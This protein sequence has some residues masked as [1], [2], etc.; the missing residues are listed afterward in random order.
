M[1]ATPPQIAR[2]LVF[3]LALA[4]VP[5][6]GQKVYIETDGSFDFTTHRR[7]QWREHPL[8]EHDPV[9]QQAYVAREVI[10]SRVNE[11]LMGMGYQPVD[12]EPDFYVTYFA[13]GH[14][15]EEL[16]VISAVGSTYWYGWGS[17]VYYD[18]WVKYGVD[19]ELNGFLVLDFVAAGTSQLG[20]R[21]ICK[22][23]IKDIKKRSDN[24]TRAVDKA[25]KKFPPK[26]G[27]RES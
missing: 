2:V 9:M 7:Y 13:G 23:T 17:N 1:G 10:R 5:A 16:K 20:W 6:F 25:M 14:I 21:A 22:D 8:A 3:A 26:P 4:A 24:I 27:S 12:H 18:G 11:K 15:T 19:Q